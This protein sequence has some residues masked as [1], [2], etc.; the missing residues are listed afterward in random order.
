MDPRLV[1]S[2]VVVVVVLMG[3]ALVNIVNVPSETSSPTISTSSVSTIRTRTTSI[4]GSSSVNLESYVVVP[5]NEDELRNTLK[6]ILELREA[7][8][9]KYG[10]TYL[11]EVVAVPTATVPAEIIEARTAKSGVEY[12]RTNV[13]VEGVDEL[14]IVK[15]DG[16]YVYVAS[17]SKLYVLKVIPNDVPKI[18]AFVDVGKHIHGILVYGDR[19]LIVATK[20]IFRIMIVPPPGS[21][22]PKVES[23]VYIYRFDGKDL[24]LEK[25]IDVEG[26]PIAGRLH[27]R[28]A[29]V[30]FVSGIYEPKPPIVGGKPLSFSN[31][32]IVDPLDPYS[33]F[34]TVLALDLENLSYNATA[35]VAGASSRIYLSKNDNLYIVAS[36]SPT[37]ILVEALTKNFDRFPNDVRKALEPYIHT[38]DVAKL[39]Q[40]FR[41]VLA[42]VSKEKFDVVTKI[43]RNYVGNATTKTLIVLLRVNGIDISFVAKRVVDGV[44]RDQFA[45]E[46]RGNYFIVATTLQQYSLYMYRYE[47]LWRTEEEGRPVAIIVQHGITKTVTLA[48]TK[49][50]SE[51]SVKTFVNVWIAPSRELWNNVYVLKLPRLE[52]VA[53]L[54]R[55]AEGER[56]YAARFLGNLMLLV[57]Y[58]RVD[59]I[60]AIDLSDPE[61]P[62]ILGFLEMPGYSEYLHP[63]NDRFV[64]GI[65][66]SDNPWGLKITVVDVSN[67][68]NMVEVSR[69]VIPD[70]YS[71]V[72]RDYHAFLHDARYHYVAIPVSIVRTMASGALVVFYDP[73]TGSVTDTKLVQHEGTLRTLYVGNELYLV[74][75][76][77]IKVVK[78]PSLEVVGSVELKP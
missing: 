19:I 77:S 40:A 26:T 14:D 72:F 59:P 11:R 48:I 74:S 53:K 43:L 8:V 36:V 9:S 16:R 18:V 73:S 3:V 1:L 25:S 55:I 44:V 10:A 23:F 62:K 66:V 6:Q 37:K 75:G 29:Y 69:V 46:E 31:V 67:P 60:F 4:A 24:M 5:R 78:I 12:S 64:I 70:A 39:L 17:G 49:Q 68:K 63:L 27:G 28:Y 15:T 35:I 42:K 30:L 71:T 65:G 47:S 21:P 56:I 32:L 51:Q 2:I 76:T 57:T 50:R 20:P 58:R 7:L 13:Q 54:E 41:D 45:V 52:I 38:K 34:N 61:H 33:A 22:P